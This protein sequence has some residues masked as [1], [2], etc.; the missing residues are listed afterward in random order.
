MNFLE[1][2]EGWRN[3]ILPPERLKD[4]IIQ[5]SKERLAICKECI[6]YD[7]TGEGCSIPGTSP[8]CNKHVKI[9]D[10]F[11][12]GCPLQKKTKCLSCECPAKKWVAISTQEQEELINKRLNN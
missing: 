1:V 3:D 7:E 12:C 4:L 8:C 5:V 10:V 9:E 6:A 2:F 11:G